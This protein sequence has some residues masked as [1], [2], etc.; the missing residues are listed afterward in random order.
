MKIVL[1]IF[2]LI[3]LLTNTKM[4]SQEHIIIALIAICIPIIVS[5]QS[6]QKE[7]PL[8]ATTCSTC[9]GAIWNN[10]GLIKGNGDG[11]ANSLLDQR[12]ETYYYSKP[13]YALNFDFHIPPNASIT[14]LKL[15][16]IKGA[17]TPG[18]IKDHTVKLINNYNSLSVNKKKG[19]FW[20]GFPISLNYGDS[21]DLWGATL[22][23]TI[24]NSPDFGVVFKCQNMDYD[25]THYA[26][27]EYFEITVY[28]SQGA[29]V[30]SQTRGGGISENPKIQIWPNP[31]NNFLSISCV[32]LIDD[33]QI[34]I[35][36]PTGQI[37]FSEKVEPVNYINPKRIDISNLPA[38]IYLIRVFNAKKD[39]T[40]NFI[41]H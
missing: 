34:E 21:T 30:F 37:A 2:Y 22:T 6:S 27:V 4:K 39:F 36:T 10:K 24:I 20:N 8:K 9:N 18:N 38:G 13:L 11:P 35:M 26:F 19:Y 5:S 14:G 25:S 3:T 32:E 7:G 29:E 12:D 16:I 23:P 33:C 17:N 15:R 41:K 28:Y 1:P 40:T 31:A